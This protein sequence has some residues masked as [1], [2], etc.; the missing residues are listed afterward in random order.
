[1]LLTSDFARSASCALS[2]VAGMEVLTSL[3]ARTLVE[4]IVAGFMLFDN[5]SM[6]EVESGRLVAVRCRGA[7]GQDADADVMR[8]KSMRRSLYADMQKQCF[9]FLK[10]FVCGRGVKLVAELGIPCTWVGGWRYL[11]GFQLLVLQ[12]FVD[13]LPFRVGSNGRPPTQQPCQEM[14]SGPTYPPPLARFQGLP[15]QKSQHC[16][17]KR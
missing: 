14:E 9:V 6:I 7:T 5:P 4:D 15:C 1:M 10:S 2:F 12:N 11:I 13:R 17:K 3:V 16:T 8:C